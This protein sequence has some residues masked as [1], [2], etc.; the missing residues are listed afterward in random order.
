MDEPNENWLTTLELISTI[1][2]SIPSSK[3]SHVPSSSA[4]TETLTRA[5]SPTHSFL[6]PE[7]IDYHCCHKILSTLADNLYDIY[8]EYKSVKELRDAI[9][10]ECD[11]DDAGM[12]ESSPLLLVSL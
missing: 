12:I 5:H 4:P 9:E 2:S 3:S 10:E 7:K 1:D 8:Y 6:K 11:L